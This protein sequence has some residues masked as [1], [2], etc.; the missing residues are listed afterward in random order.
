[1][2]VRLRRR[3]TVRSLLGTSCDALVSIASGIPRK[4][5]SAWYSNISWR[6]PK[7]RRAGLFA[8]AARG[9]N[10]LRGMHYCMN[11]CM[12]VVSDVLM[13]LSNYG[14]AADDLCGIGVCAYSIATADLAAMIAPWRRSSG[15]IPRARRSDLWRVSIRSLLASMRSRTP[16]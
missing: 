11:S 4:A 6:L 1:M 2:F 15:G 5:Q 14:T 12:G 3:S 8:Q 16:L 13:S 10:H 7:M 9:D